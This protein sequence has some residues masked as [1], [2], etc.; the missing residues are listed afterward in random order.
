MGERTGEDIWERN[1][2][3]DGE[4]LPLFTQDEETMPS[5]CTTNWD[6]T[7]ATPTEGCLAWITLLT[8]YKE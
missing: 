8:E 1:I 2:G 7:N 6:T 5:T 4:P 3:F